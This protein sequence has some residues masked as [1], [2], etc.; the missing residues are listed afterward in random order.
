MATE[1][2]KLFSEN[3]HIRE[4]TGVTKFHKAGY[5]GKRV[6]AAT[7]ESWDTS[8]YNPDD[9]VITPFG[10]GKG[11]GNFSG[12]H[13]T[14]TA[15]TFFQVAPQSKLVQLDKVSSTM[16][17][18]SGYCGLEKYCLEEIKKYNI[19]SMFCSFDMYCDT[20]LSQRYS[21][22]IKSLGT[23]NLFVAAGNHAGREYAR[24]L[25]CEDVC[26]AGACYIDGS[27]IRTE[28]FTSLTE[29]VDFAAPDRQTVKFAKES[30]VIEWGKQ[31]GTS[32][33]TPWL[34]GMACLVNDFFIDKTG[35]PITHE[36]MMKFFADHTVD[37]G[38]EGKDK[39]SG[40]GMVVLPDPSEIDIAKYKGENMIEKFKDA[41]QVSDWA[42]KAVDYC[43]EKG[44]L[45]GKGD[46]VFDPQGTLTREEFCCVIKRVVDDLSNGV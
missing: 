14:K 44:Y 13:G 34:C 42:I 4:M 10:N 30:G 45:N 46:N 26:G 39:Q 7:G 33:S 29:Y 5:F 36:Q 28:D 2:N 19:T 24:L 35:S 15:A 20:Y 6:T 27:K 38:V 12:G 16:S 18:K 40:L 11:W 32:F 17:G 8:N 1:S 3:D 9:L 31:S 25:E 22:V 43:L 37:I 23:F 41:K 21:N